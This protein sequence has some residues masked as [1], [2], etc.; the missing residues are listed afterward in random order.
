MAVNGPSREE[1]WRLAGKTALVTGGSKGIGR[2][3]VEELAGFGVRV[4]TCARHDAD[5]QECLRRW[6]ADDRLA[7]VTATACDVSVRGDRE[8]LVAAARDELGGRLDILVNNAGQTFFK[9][10]TDCSAEDYARLMATNL[11]SCFHL[12]QLAH[13]LLLLASSSGGGA[14]S[15]SSVVN[16]SSIAGFVSYPTLSVYSATKGAMNQLTRSLAAEWAK[17][18]I[19][20]NCVA[21]GGVRTEIT[22]SSGIKMDPEVAQKMV[23]AELARVPM[24]RLGEP[25]EIASMVTFLCMPAASYVTGQVICADGGRTI[26]A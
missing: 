15:S 2:A 19:R 3:I 13:P 17:D 21:P 9:P 6:R 1:R 20:V 22:A 14:S 7:R 11:E 5:L 26:A 8:R 24:H 23:A 10:A 4:H 25:E 18:N 12:A 16:I